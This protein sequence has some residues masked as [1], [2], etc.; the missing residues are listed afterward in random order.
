MLP[1]SSTLIKKL[2]AEPAPPAAPLH[3]A[4]QQGSHDRHL[5]QGRGTPLNLRLVTPTTPINRPRSCPSNIASHLEKTRSD[6]VAT[7]TSPLTSLGSKAPSHLEA[8]TPDAPPQG[9]SRRRTT[10]RPL[11]ATL[12]DVSAH[13]TSTSYSLALL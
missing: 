6:S 10:T 3:A 9:P 8:T 12:T 2:D 7:R 4:R 5:V 13:E 1:P 11:A